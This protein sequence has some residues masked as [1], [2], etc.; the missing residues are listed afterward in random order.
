MVENTQYK[1]NM[2]YRE[3][4]QTHPPDSALLSF[5]AR[6]SRWGIGKKLAADNIGA[7]FLAGFVA[8]HFNNIQFFSQ[9]ISVIV[10]G[11]MA[12]Y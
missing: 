4:P 2:V 6:S 9:E 1:H 3:V 10:E 11:R 8:F 7:R 12:E 5:I